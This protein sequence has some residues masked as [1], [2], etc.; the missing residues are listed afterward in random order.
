ML[1]SELELSLPYV[2]AELPG[3]GGVLRASPDDFVVEEVP[4]YA[5]QGDGQHL[6][7]NITKVGLTTK[8]VQAGLE[9]LFGLKRGDVSFAGMKDKR[10]RTTQ[11]FSL[12]VGHK[13]PA[14]AEASAAQ[15]EANL[16]VTVNWVRFHRN[17]LKLGHL[18]GNRFAIRITQL[19]EPVAVAQAH[20]AAVVQRLLATG[21]PNYFGVQRLGEGGVNVRQGRAIVGGERSQRDR[22]LQRFLISAY[23]S[24]L[25]NRYLAQRLATGTF[26]RLLTG[27]VAKK[28]ATGGMFD[29]VDGEAEQPRY[30]AQEISFTAPIFG[31]RMWAAKDAAGEL[32]AAVLHQAGVTLE[33][34]GRLHVEGTRRMGRLLPQ[35]LRVTAD[36]DSLTLYFELRKGAFATTVLR[37]V[38]KI[39]AAAL[40]AAAAIDDDD[41][42]E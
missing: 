3:T 40:S 42:D 5:A 13:P 11:T 32:E 41:G 26:D 17:K 30:A 29:V 16:P 15:I 38:M 21:L 18:L 37:E 31:P 2:T 25:C 4:L 9:R 20:A 22:W 1:Q 7:V 39:D 8:E 14:F 36:N 23:Q 12:S 27:D 10:A 35:D 34:F 19:A 28:Y 6:Y 24:Y 33:D